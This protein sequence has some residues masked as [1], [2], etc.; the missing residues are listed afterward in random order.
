MDNLSISQLTRAPKAQPQTSLIVT[1]RPFARTDEVGCFELPEGLTV[2]QMV[3]RLELAGVLDPD[4]RDLVRVTAGDQLLPPDL[5]PVA[6]P[7]SGVVLFIDVAPM[8]GSNALRTILQ[9]AVIAFS[10]FLPGALGLTG[11]GAAIAAASTTAGG[12]ILTKLPRDACS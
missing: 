5:W 8:K 11:F 12:S 9:I 3:D 2:A 4:L 10:V 1:P 7:K 6:R